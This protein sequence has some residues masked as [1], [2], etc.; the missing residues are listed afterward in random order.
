MTDTKGTTCNGWT[1]YATW[2][3]N[4]EICDDLCSLRQSDDDPFDS[5]WDLSNYLR[6][7]TTELV[8]GE[9]YHA[10]HLATQ[11]A[12]AFL[13]QVNWDEIARS[14]A[15][16]LAR[17]EIMERTHAREDDDARL[18]DTLEGGSL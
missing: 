10:K 11:Y 1:N 16:E 7:A 14:N 2:R 5:V 3:I 8:C 17:A 4:L 13:D 12:L 15:D 9:D 18:Y 6:E